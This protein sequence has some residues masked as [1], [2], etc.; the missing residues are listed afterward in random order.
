MLEKVRLKSRA[1]IRKEV[2]LTMPQS[3]AQ[4]VRSLRIARKR[5]K[6]SD[7]AYPLTKATAKPIAKTELR[8]ALKNLLSRDRRKVNRHGSDFGP[9]GS[10]TVMPKSPKV[11]VEPVK[12]GWQY[13]P[14]GF[15]GHKPEP[16]NIS[17]KER[18]K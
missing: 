6:Q 17:Y 11:T 2:A 12:K 5:Q 1:R 9:R 16:R 13:P 10:V 7:V 15:P 4:H 3:R 14:P 18:N 8:S